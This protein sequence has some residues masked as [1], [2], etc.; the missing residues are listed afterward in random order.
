M[1]SFPLVLHRLLGIHTNYLCYNY[2]ITFACAHY[3]NRTYFFRFSFSI[4]CVQFIKYTLSILINCAVKE[5]YGILAH[6]LE[7]R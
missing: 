3:I 7:N 4:Q 1:L 6:C 2:N 5:I